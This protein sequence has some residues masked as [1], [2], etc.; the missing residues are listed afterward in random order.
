MPLDLTLTPLYRTEGKE[1]ASMPGLLPAMPPRKTA[2]GREHDRLVVYL[3]LTGNTS[4]ST[5]EYVQFANRAAATF[6]ETSGT[7]TFALRAAAEL[8]NKLLLERNLSTSGRGQ[9]A[10]GLLS[11]VAM[12]ESEATLLL[13]GPMHAYVLNADGA[14]QIFDSLSG[15]GLGLGANAPHHFSRISLQPNDRL[16]LYAKIPFAWESALKDLSPASLEA[17]RRRLM[18]LTN[19]NVNAVLLQATEG[20]GALIVMR[21]ESETSAPEEPAPPSADASTSLSTGEER[22]AE[23]QPESMPNAHLVQASAYAIPPQPKEEELPSQP[24][25]PDYSGLPATPSTF[26]VAASTN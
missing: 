5:D 12:R 16:V 20:N 6:Y 13:S 3:L 24:F 4:Y 19:D 26:G 25:E 15:N 22:A 18:N 9:Y 2:R 7:L 14:H 21:P 10:V 8:I 1:Q 11:L 23:P 17:T